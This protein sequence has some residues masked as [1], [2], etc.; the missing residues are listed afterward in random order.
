MKNIG[1]WLPLCILFFLSVFSLYMH[2]RIRRRSSLHPSRRLVYCVQHRLGVDATYVKEL[3]MYLP[4]RLR[5]LYQEDLLNVSLSP[6]HT[7]IACQL[8]V[9]EIARSY[10]PNLSL[11]LTGLA[12]KL[13]F[14]GY[15]TREVLY[16]AKIL[17]NKLS[18]R[19]G[20]IDSQVYSKC[21]QQF[22]SFIFLLLCLLYVT[23][24]EFESLRIQLK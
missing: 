22:I 14:D 10:Y 17:G 18:P 2:M 19:R 8:I 1:I 15:V 23:P 7:V 11:T 6:R 3:A 21:A 9:A 20:G 12:E 5:Q 4:E 16:L 24:K 13:L